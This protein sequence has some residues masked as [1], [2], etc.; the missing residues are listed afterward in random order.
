MTGKDGK[1]FM[2]SKI[3]LIPVMEQIDWE[4]CC[5]CELC[6]NVC[7]AG[8]I[9]MAEDD[10][11]FRYPSLN[12]GACTHCNTCVIRCPVLSPP[13]QSMEKTTFAGYALNP[14]IVKFSSSGGF[15]SLLAETFWSEHDDAYI[16]GVVWA[17]DFKST[18][19]VITNDPRELERLKLSKYIQSQ[20]GSVYQQIET[21]LKDGAHVMFVGCPCEAVALANYL[22][23]PY[24][25]LLIID[26][27][28]QGP[29]SP[30]AMR[31]YVDRTEDRR[32]T[33]ITAVNMRYPIGPWIPQYI[34][35]DFAKGSPFI[36]ML[37]ETDVGR[38]LKL[39]QRPSCYRCR[40]AGDNRMSDITL[41]D[42]HG[43]DTAAEYYNKTGTSILV[44][45]TDK[46]KAFA[47]CLTPERVKLVSIPY[48]A[49]S[50]PNPRMDRP[51]GA[52]PRSKQFV[53][54]F[55]RYGLHIAARKSFPLKQR[56]F[57]ALPR[58]FRPLAKSLMRLFR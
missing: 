19:H 23:K 37:Y 41:G 5:G 26:L 18:L 17:D 15:F 31:E 57:H 21:L 2:H 24:E 50:G 29:T 40:Y 52:D 54:D 6:M 33:R 3:M 56:F 27:V 47:S 36:K 39:M 42:F 10:D 14:S 1:P 35:V 53:D 45:N 16:A 38:A 7:P 11:G 48:E 20:K 58:Q 46:G 25:R 12:T 4:D 44:L 13:K 55:K 34:K 30:R 8:A 22:R 51:W 28:C 43:P 32:K 49:A 9:V